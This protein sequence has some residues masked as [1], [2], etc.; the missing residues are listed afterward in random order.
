MGFDVSALSAYT[1]ERATEF[2]SKALLG[3]KVA[4]QMTVIDGIK[5][6]VKLPTEEFG[7]D[8][9]QS[10]NSCTFTDGNNDLVIAQR[11]LTPV[12][13]MINETFCV[14][15]LEPYFTQKILKPGGI[16]EDVPAEL[17]LFDMIG[18]SVQKAL[19]LAL[20]RGVLGGA[21][22]IASFNLFDGMLE[23]ASNDIA[24]GDIPAAQQL[25]G[26]LTTTNIIASFRAMYDNMDLD[27][28]M[29]IHSQGDWKIYCSPLAAVIY[30]RDF[31]T[32]YGT[33]HNGDGFDKTHLDN[34]GI[35][36][37]P[38]A[39][40]AEDDSQAIL[41]RAGNYWMGVDVEGEET[42][43]SLKLGAG[44]EAKTLYL[45]GVFKMGIQTKFPEQMVTN[46]I[47]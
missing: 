5:S 27:S 23:T 2:Y 16:Y 45:S 17:R 18:M 42:D 35:E 7:Y 15:T 19:E 14:K 34:T 31:Q 25:T 37:V 39:G 47:S 46:N 32:A 43:L 41:T 21:S 11:T 4:Q 30:E 6:A 28:R 9:F 1:E 24:A 26:A 22:A 38:L 20:V 33:S 29:N 10:D 12:D 13:I 3:S 8:I 44:T 40:F 36:I